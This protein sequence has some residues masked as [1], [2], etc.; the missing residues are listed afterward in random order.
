M[1]ACAPRVYRYPWGPEEGVQSPG[2]GVTIDCELLGVGAGG[3]NLA[4][5]KEK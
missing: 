2:P 1:C 4:S 3:L 5:L